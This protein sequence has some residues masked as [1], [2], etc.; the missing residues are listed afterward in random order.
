MECIFDK[1]SKL[2]TAL[3]A[4]AIGARDM[5]RFMHDYYEGKEPVYPSEMEDI[6]IKFLEQYFV[7]KDIDQNAV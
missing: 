4:Y 5:M 3:E 6:Y 1:D 2:Y 7:V